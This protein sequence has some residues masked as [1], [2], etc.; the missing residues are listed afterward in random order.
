MEGFIL[1]VQLWAGGPVEKWKVKDCRE[2][3]GWL[4]EAW[5]WSERSGV[6]MVAGPIFVCYEVELEDKRTKG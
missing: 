1:S 3:I 6:D 5:K 2:G 4:K